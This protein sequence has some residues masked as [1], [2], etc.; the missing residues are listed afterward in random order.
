MNDLVQWG[1]GVIQWIQSFRNPFLDQLILTINF[2][3][4]EDFYLLFLPVL[5]WCLHKQVGIRL[6]FVLLF[7]F[8]L[9]SSLKDLLA[10]PRPYQVDNK[11]Y[12]P[13]PQP[14]YGTG[15]A[16]GGSHKG[17]CRRGRSSSLIARR[18]R[19]VAAGRPGGSGSH[20][21]PRRR[22]SPGR[23]ARYWDR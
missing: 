14:G 16:G 12:A 6:S 4:E 15:I 9:N 20:R 8:Y 11:L 18:C 22:E 19:V 5:F 13:I 2:L 3:G 21:C 10:A 7:T 1:L 17:G 23:P